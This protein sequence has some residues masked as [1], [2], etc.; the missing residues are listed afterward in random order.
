MW[1]DL[2]RPAD[3]LMRLAVSRNADGRL[4]VFGVGSHIWHNWELAANSYTWR[5]WEMLGTN[6][7][8]GTN[9]VVGQNSD[10]RLEVFLVGPNNNLYHNSQNAPV[11]GTGWSGWQIMGNSPQVSADPDSLAVASEADGRLHVFAIDQNNGAIWH[12]YQ[13]LASEGGGWSYFLEIGYIADRNGYRLAVGRNS[14][15]LCL[16]VFLV[17]QDHTIWHAWET[18]ENGSNYWSEWAMLGTQTDAGYLLKVGQNADGHLEVFLV[19]MDF[20]VWHNWQMAPQSGSPWSGWNH[21]G[22]LPHPL[23]PEAEM[24][25]AVGYD[26]AGHLEVFVIDNDAHV[27]YT[28]QAGNW[29]SWQ[30]LS[31]TDLFTITSG[32]VIVAQNEQSR[33]GIP[34]PYGP[35]TVFMM[36][37]STWAY[38]VYA[39]VDWLTEQPAFDAVYVSQSVPPSVTA[40]STFTA[41]ITMR[42]TGRCIWTPGGLNPLRIGSQNPQDNM[43]WGL[44]R[45]DVPST[46]PPGMQVTFNLTLT[47]PAVSGTYNFQWQ[48]VEEGI[49]WFGAMTLNMPVIVTGVKGKEK[50][51]EKDKDKDGKDHKDLRDGTGIS[52]QTSMMDALGNPA[53]MDA[54]D[55]QAANGETFISSQERPPVGTHALEQAL[56]EE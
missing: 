13:Q 24:H 3:L 14:V 43:I 19:G 18:R 10:G 26:E 35:L 51:K 2:G 27:Y 9:L 22:T 41:T 44:G 28:S 1:T 5:G 21:L 36:G 12:S 47:A 17:K 34:S 48:M 33:F 6:S 54:I 20:N 56:E 23:L 30:V 55:E 50:E 37:N 16:E 38:S 29:G 40:K 46:V 4:E 32:S 8:G 53:E 25:L 39:F 52:S 15:S 7:D 31:L 49:S 42:N 45:M 11:N